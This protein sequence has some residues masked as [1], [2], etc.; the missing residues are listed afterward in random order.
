MY[1]YRMVIACTFDTLK[2]ILLYISFINGMNSG[3]L[4]VLVFLHNS[5]ATFTYIKY[6]NN[7][8]SGKW[9]RYNLTSD[10]FLKADFAQL[11]SHRWFM[12]K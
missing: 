12:V 9:F 6:L 3:L 2:Y 8:T 5:N 10:M 1:H 7:F 4:L 11:L